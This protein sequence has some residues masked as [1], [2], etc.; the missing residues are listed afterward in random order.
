MGLSFKGMGDITLD[1]LLKKNYDEG[2][3]N[4]TTT[5]VITDTQTE[6]VVD[7]T[8]E[9]VM[10]IGEEPTNTEDVVPDAD[11][12]DS[13]LRSLAQELAD[14]GFI[15]ALPENVDIDNFSL[16]GFKETI[17]FN[18]EKVKSNSY[19]SGR[20]YEAERLNNSLPPLVIE[21]VNYSLENPNIDEND[22][23][24]Y[25]ERKNYGDQVRA[26]NPEDITDAE[27]IIREARRMDGFSDREIDEEIEGYRE[28]NNLQRIARNLKTKLEQNVTA[29]DNQIKD[30]EEQ[31]RKYDQQ[32]ADNLK[33]RA[34]A[35]LS[36]GELNGVVL[37]KEEADYLMYACTQDV[38]VPIKGGKKVN[39]GF[40]EAVSYAN[41][42]DE[43]G[44][45]ENFMLSQLVLRFGPS[46]I[47]KFFAK[48]AK[49]NETIRFIKENKISDAKRSG[50]AGFQETTSDNSGKLN[51]AKLLTNKK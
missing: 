6:E 3:Q 47:E 46:S 20:Q 21:L 7:T 34:G 32:Q 19:E 51:F 13:S 1:S 35:I 44:S 26:L 33:R 14:N 24:E 22:V 10:S 23:L 42:Y 17:K 30:R 49:T 50:Q 8:V 2:D 41:K 45:L 5:D 31:I 29:R 27:V 11:D 36:K 18:L 15:E 39:I 25:F 4:E 12:F 37:T 16:D 40:S 48:K 9:D 43:K 28:A 38:N